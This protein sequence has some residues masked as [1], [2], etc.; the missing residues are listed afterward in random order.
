M[1]RSGS[2]CSTAMVFFGVRN[3]LQRRLR[4][5]TRK[6]RR[7]SADRGF[8]Y[9]WRCIRSDL[10]GCDQRPGNAEPDAGGADRQPVIQC[11]APNGFQVAVEHGVDNG[12]ANIVRGQIGEASANGADASR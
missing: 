12:G 11:D 3:L 10:A 9:R 6:A 1:T 4:T 7:R 5:T 2:R 8:G